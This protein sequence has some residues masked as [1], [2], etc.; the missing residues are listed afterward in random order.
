MSGARGSRRSLRHAQKS[1]DSKLIN[2]N[3]NEENFRWQ[4][5]NSFHSTEHQFF[6]EEFAKGSTD[7][8]APSREQ[9]M[10]TFKEQLAADREDGPGL[11]QPANVDQQMS[12]KQLQV[13]QK[14][15]EFGRELGMELYAGDLDDSGDFD[16]Q[17]NGML[18]PVEQA[19]K[20]RAEA[21]GR[22]ITELP[23]EEN[24]QN[25]FNG[26]K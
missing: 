21:L 8:E 11:G 5:D 18:V 16:D 1:S 17:I 13:D 26:Y 22:F 9:R 19:E 25:F 14:A 23:E 10:A 2:E 6:Y 4:G 20:A 7:I 24:T 12:H 15:A 3:L